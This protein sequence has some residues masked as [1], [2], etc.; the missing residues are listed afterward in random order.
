[1]EN[2]DFLI[3]IIADIREVTGVGHRPCLDKLAEAIRV[4]IEAKIAAAVAVEREACVR[5]CEEYAG[6]FRKCYQREHSA[7]T[8]AHDIK[9]RGEK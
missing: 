1:M 9:A 4:S 5:L 3:D 2:D 6:E 7:L 8:L